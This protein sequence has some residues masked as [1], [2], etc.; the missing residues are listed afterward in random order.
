MDWMADNAMLL[1][2]K[3]LDTAWAKQ[4]LTLDNISN[5]DTPG[6]KAKYVV[7]ED[8]LQNKLSQFAGE[9]RPKASEIRSAVAETRMRVFNSTEESMRLDGNNVNADV[10]ELELTRNVYE[11]QYALRQITEQFTRL[12]VA[13]EG[14]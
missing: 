9:A 10:E 7:F 3:T 4:R 6:Y 5:V 1:T 14:K 12:R 8:L 11:Y 2:Q 13:I